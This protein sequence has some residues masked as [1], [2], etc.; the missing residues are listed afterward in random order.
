MSAPRHFC[1]DGN[2]KKHKPPFY[3]STAEAASSAAHTRGYAPAREDSVIS[4]A[5]QWPAPTGVAT[6]TTMSSRQL[7]VSIFASAMRSPFGSKYV[8]LM[9]NNLEDAI[10]R[11]R[12]VLGMGGGGP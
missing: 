10:G 5:R 9:S 4:V 8:T 3:F 6:D 11:L 7:R 1:V 2:S 12:A